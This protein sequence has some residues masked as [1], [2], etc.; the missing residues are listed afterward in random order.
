[1]FG[2]NKNIKD[3][4][5]SSNTNY[6]ISAQKMSSFDSL[7]DIKISYT[8]TN[9]LVT[10]MY[11]VTDIMDK[12]EPIRNK[13]RTLS[14]EILSDID[15]ENRFI[16]SK[17]VAIV[18]ELLDMSLALNMISVMNK[19]I[20]SREFLDLKKALLTPKQNEFSLEGFLVEED[21]FPINNI[22]E[23]N[24]QNNSLIYKGHHKGHIKS[25]NLGVQKGSTLMK[26]ISDKT[27]T[28]Q[29]SDSFD[30]LKKE[31]RFEI[32]K[33]IKNIK[34]TN[35]KAG[36]ATIKDIKEAKNLVLKSC[37]EKTLQRELISMVKDHVLNKIGEKRW[38]KYSLK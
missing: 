22:K 38:S 7:K 15:T 12:S 31:R 24:T 2:E 17:K 6:Q 21:Q 35:P 4:S 37:S 1:M 3:S 11:M 23:I 30:M 34:D 36:G 27:F 33:I 32:V 10:A 13:L 14:I 8:K 5:N 9:K 18:L 25:T 19:N 26:A 20:L 16:L 28:I 29:H